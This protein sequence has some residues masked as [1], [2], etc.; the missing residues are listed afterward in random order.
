MTAHSTP[1]SSSQP[2]CH[3]QLASR[4]RKHLHHPSRRPVAEHTRAA[5]EAIREQ[6]EN[7]SRPLVF[8]SYCGTGMSSGLLAQRLPG[9]LVIGIDKSAARLSRQPAGAG[10]NSLLVRADCGDFWRLAADAGWRLSHHFLL[11]PNPWPK[12]G[13]L[14]RRLHGAPEFAQL[15]RLGGRVEL[16]S[17]WQVYVE[18]FGQALV[19]AGHWPAVDSPQPTQP[20]SLHERK[21]VDS[22]HLIWRCRCHLGHNSRP[23]E[24]RETR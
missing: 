10:R 16:R 3:P 19:I 13:H 22:G 5:F 14:G 18:E 12:P 24:A 15:L 8:D 20:I 6:V 21:Y 17:N 2:G 7:D 4:V 1:V 11:Y 23:P 9:H